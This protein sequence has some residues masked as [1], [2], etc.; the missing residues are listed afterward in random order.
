MVV[1]ETERLL[2]RQMSAEDAEFVFELVNEPAFIRNIGDKGVRN[3]N[4]ARDYILNGPIA[5]Y[6]KNGFGLYCVEMKQTGE[7]IGMCGLLKRDAL[8]DVDIG[9]AF[10]EKF[11]GC[12]YGTESAS[13]VMEH[14]RRA[15]GIQRIVAITSPDND[16]SIHVLE[17]IGLR[18]EKMIQMP[19]STEDTRLFVPRE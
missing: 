12:G 17:K 3:L 13:A 16:A 18:F 5:S 15:L 8:D 7:T 2:L 6:A 14:A 19:G 10:L 11:R 4:D 9:F 1:L